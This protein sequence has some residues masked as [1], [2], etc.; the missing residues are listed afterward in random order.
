MKTLS[1]FHLK[2]NG[3]RRRLKIQSL[4]DNGGLV[5]DEEGINLVAANLYRNLFGPPVSY[6]VNINDLEME[7]LNDDDRDSLTT[8]FS[9]SEIKVVD[10]LKHSAPVLMAYL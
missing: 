10:N 9:V 8:P 6:F 7:K 1:I 4:M 5:E 2:A 3:N